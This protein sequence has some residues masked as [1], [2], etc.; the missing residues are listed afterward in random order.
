MPRL[1]FIATSIKLGGKTITPS[2]SAQYL[3]SNSIKIFPAGTLTS[4]LDNIS[5]TEYT[6]NKTYSA[7]ITALDTASASPNNQV[8][9]V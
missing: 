9:L 7:T 3:E 4:I 5:Q 2:T 8:D 1:K 6:I